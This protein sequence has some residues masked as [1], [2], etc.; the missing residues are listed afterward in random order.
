M[1]D[2]FAHL[3]EADQHRAAAMELQAWRRHLAEHH[4]NRTEIISLEMAIALLEQ[5]AESL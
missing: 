4:M 2:L 3:S 5:K 1:N